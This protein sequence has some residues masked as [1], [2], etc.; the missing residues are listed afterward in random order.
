MLLLLSILC[1]VFFPSLYKQDDIKTSRLLSTDNFVQHFVERKWL[2]PRLIIKKTHVR[3]VN[4]AGI[5]GSGSGL[6]F[7]KTLG[8]FRARYDACK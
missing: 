7:R 3:V 6:T 8:L 5:F 2:R 1:L 4:R